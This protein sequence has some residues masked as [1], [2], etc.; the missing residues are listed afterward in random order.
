MSKVKRVDES[1]VK[2]IENIK[3]ICADS[4][5]NVTDK[6]ITKALALTLPPIKQVKII[7]LKRKK[8]LRFV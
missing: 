1:F 2:W 8:F 5:I 4:K 7:R 6:D 3:K